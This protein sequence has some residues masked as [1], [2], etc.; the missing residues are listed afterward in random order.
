M[1]VS[2]FQNNDFSLY[3]GLH[4]NVFLVVFLSLVA[5]LLCGPSPNDP[6]LVGFEDTLQAS[7]L[8]SSL[9]LSPRGGGHGRG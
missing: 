9:H 3:L 4:L 6:V 2:R 8:C 7:S 1:T 5:G